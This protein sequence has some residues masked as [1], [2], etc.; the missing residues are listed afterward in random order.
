MLSVL[1]QPGGWWWLVPLCIVLSSP[2]AEAGKLRRFERAVT[3]PKPAPPAAPSAGTVIVAPMVVAPCAA[4]PWDCGYGWWDDLRWRGSRP[5]ELRE[6]P[7]PVEFTRVP[8]DYLLPEFRVEA[9]YHAVDSDIYGVDMRADMGYRAANIAMRY[10]QFIDHTN[11]ERLGL[12][13]GQ[14]ML[15]VVPD[16]HIEWD[17]GLSLVNLRGAANSTGGGI[18]MAFTLAPWQH[19]AVQLQP[20]WSVVHD[21]FLQDIDIKFAYTLP[22]VSLHAGYR[23]LSGEGEGLTGPYMGTAWRW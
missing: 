18:L 3:K 23:W 8:G 9:N 6:G 17:L 5:R 20:A 12:M 2:A 4:W 7:P 19:A 15:R 16:A 1:R 13:Y 22:F 21:N 11:N 10:T 14:A